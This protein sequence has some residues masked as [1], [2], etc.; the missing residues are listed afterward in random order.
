MPDNKP[1]DVPVEELEVHQENASQADTGDGKKTGEA[2]AD[3]TST[4]S[5][6]TAPK[7]LLSHY[8]GMPKNW[9]K[10]RAPAKDS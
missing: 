2:T 10:N 9:E 3:T 4:T 6:E 7:Q 5:R 8:R 1:S